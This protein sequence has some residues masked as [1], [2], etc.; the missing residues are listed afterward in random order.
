MIGDRRLEQSRLFSADQERERFLERLG[1]RVR[2]HEVRLYLFVLMTNHFHL[3]FE[4][5][6]GNCS[7]FMQ[8]LLT[9]YTVYYNL[10]H[11]RHGHLFDGRFKAKVVEG[12]QYLLALTRYVH[13]NPVMAGGIKGRP[14]NDKID[15]LRGYKWSTYRSYL[16]KARE[17]DFVS[18]GPVLAQMEGK[19]RTRRRRYAEYVERGL[20]Q[21]DEEFQELLKESPRSIGGEGFRAWVDDL[22]EKVMGGHEAEDVA[23]RR[24]TEPL[25]PD[26][27]LGTV[28]DVF[29]VK[30]EDLCRRRRD[31]G[32]R[33]AA[34]RCLIRY[35]GM[36]QREAGELLKA[37]SGSAISKQLA[38]HR[39]EMETG[40]LARLL[41]RAENL[42]G[43][44]RKKRHDNSYLKG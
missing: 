12:D 7:R 5:P 1:E 6:E 28:A 39:D 40:G 23:F 17:F 44:A 32:C 33:A 42:L 18:Y 24:V 19:E 11:G 15:Y 36:S 37:G 35:A 27:V 38:A 21:T 41:A 31:S 9:S 20:A 29:G 26:I 25:G 10:R 14:A 30:V 3:V 43:E 8:S 22:Y 34:A 2:E 4:T 16:G 13:L